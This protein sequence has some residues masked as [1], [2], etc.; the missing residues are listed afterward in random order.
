MLGLLGF[1]VA[2]GVT[3]LIF[4]RTIA[5]AET[6]A[7]R[8]AFEIVVITGRIEPAEATFL[9]RAAQIRIVSAEGAFLIAHEGKGQEL[10]DHIGAIVTLTAERMHDDEGYEILSVERYRV[11]RS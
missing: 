10:K 3:P 4:D 5:W 1:A 8:P 6:A 9:G 2:T 11:H 7:A